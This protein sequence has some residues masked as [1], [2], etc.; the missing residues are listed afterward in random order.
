LPGYREFLEKIG[1]W[2]SIVA[3]LVSPGGLT[4]LF[5]D[6]FASDVLRRFAIGATIVASVLGFL[7]AASGIENWSTQR[8]RDAAAHSLILFVVAA[9]GCAFLL[10]A[11][12]PDVASSFPLFRATGRFLVLATPFSNF[13]IA[14]VWGTSIGS[15]VFTLVT[16]SPNLSA[17]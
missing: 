14:A 10:T 11:L 9:L 8:R 6:L 4:W 5:V 15:L 12:R 2:W 16:L 1:I 13:V 7:L 17:H 3:A